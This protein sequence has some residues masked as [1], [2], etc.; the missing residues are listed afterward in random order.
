MKPA[1]TLM[2]KLKQAGIAAILVHHANKSGDNYRGSTAIAATFE[3]IM[4]LERAED[5]HADRRNSAGFLIKADKFRGRRD[6]TMEARKAFL[7]DGNWELD[8]VEDQQAARVVQAIRMR[9]YVNQREIGAALGVNQTTVARALKRAV[10]LGLITEKE[11]E[12][13]AKSARALRDDT[14][15]VAFGDEGDN[16]DF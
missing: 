12:E 16:P 9:R 10:G 5:P 3:V 2:L 7:V 11:V 13:C 4:G 1:L 14:V 8:G 15:R 6:D